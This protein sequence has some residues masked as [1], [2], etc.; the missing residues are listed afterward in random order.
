MITSDE[1]YLLHRYIVADLMHRTLM[2]DWQYIEP[3]KMA[4]V[5]SLW[6]EQ[7]TIT[8]R[9]ECK[10]LKSQL[11]AKGLKILRLTVLDEYFCIYTIGTRGEDM[12]LQYAINALKSE[13]QDEVQKRLFALNTPM[14]RKE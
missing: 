10:L 4:E 13:V 7:Q 14:Q 12:D 3:M 1:R 5:F 2:K 9:R 6:F 8:L 11:Q